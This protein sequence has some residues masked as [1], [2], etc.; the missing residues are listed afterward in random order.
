MI[1]RF[2]PSLIV[3]FYAASALAMEPF[4]VKDIRVDGIQRTEAG[5]VFNYL[6]VKVG[7]VMDDDK[8]AQAIKSLYSTGFF[9]DVRLEAE[10]NVLVIT[11]AERP[12]IAQIDFSG[13]KAFPSDKM[14][15]GLKMIGLAEGMIFDRA[16]LDK[17]EQ[18]IKRQYLSQ[19]KYGATVKAVTNPLERNRVSIRF[20]I[21]E[22]AISRIRAI[23]IV[24][25]QSFEQEDLRE[26]FALTTPNWLSWWNKDDQYSKQKLTADLEA[27][28][29]FYM[30]QGYLE[31]NI[32]STQVSITPDKRDIYIT[33]NITEG[34]KYTVTDVKMA[35]EMMVPEDELR[36]LVTVQPG[37][38]FNRERLT[39]TSKAIGDRLGNDGYAFANVNAVPEV[40]KDKKTVAF[41]FFVDP[42]RRVYVRR[43]NLTGNTTTRDEVL[44]REMRQL[45]SS[46]YAA[47][48]I[49]RSKQRLDRTGYFSEVNLETPAVPGT[50]DQVDLNINV[51]ERSTG[52]VQFGAGLSSAEGVVFGLTVNQSNFLGTG[53]RVSA[54]VNTGQVNTTYSLSYTDPY[55]TPDGIT[56]GFDVYR[57]DVDA[58]SLDVGDFK[59]SSY[60]AGVRFGV[61]VNERDMVSAGL[62]FDYTKYDLSRNSPERFLRYCEYN[63]S[64]C[65]DYTLRLDLGWT[66]DSRDNVLFPN[67]GVLQ[68]FTTEVGLPGLDQ[69]Y[70]RLNYQHTWYKDFTKNI[71]LMLNGEAGYAD[72]Y[73]S[74]D[75]PFN[76]NFFTGGVNSVRGYEQSAI[77][78]RDIDPGPDRIRGTADDGNDYAV[79]GT[80]RVV[81]NA[82]LFVPVPFIK[83]TKQWRLSAFVDAGS[84]WGEQ[85]GVVNDCSGAS[86]CLRY[87]TGIG[88]SWFSPFGPIKVVLA[89]PLNQQDGDRTETLQFQLGSGF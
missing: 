85:S 74:R 25:N 24:G 17:A 59:T 50:A 20:D 35:G 78:P 63:D 8:A 55:F 46:W 70:Y 68:R 4:Q 72:S 5:T 83:D 29:S 1:F 79:G 61:P 41:T 28:R 7:D 13:N 27:L 75:Y 2:I 48:K 31:F 53:N 37:E 33:I 16:M 77:G 47:D 54:Q 51:T 3:F 66:H 82:E 52:S 73:G 15:E 36:K 32:D 60:G 80:K 65:V 87:S 6:P 11:V 64:G 84:V 71:T 49:N 30:N 76:K 39:E 10:G 69:E 42:G 89:K 9:K 81:A 58:S 14:K 67:K 34:D 38:V 62:T 12:A 86:D 26:Q 21:E 88:V 57:R 40:D 19:G 23:N 18:E 43:I 56:R 44:R 22:G 45:E